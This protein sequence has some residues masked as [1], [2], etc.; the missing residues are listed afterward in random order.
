MADSEMFEKKRADYLKFN[1]NY[2]AGTFLDNNI[3]KSNYTKIALV[4]TIDTIQNWSDLYQKFNLGENYSNKQFWQDESK[5][6]VDVTQ[7]KEWLEQLFKQEFNITAVGAEFL[8]GVGN[9][10][11]ENSVQLTEAVDAENNCY[12]ILQSGFTALEAKSN[13]LKKSAKYAYDKDVFTVDQENYVTYDERNLDSLIVTM[14][15]EYFD[16]EI[17]AGELKQNLPA[18]RV[19]GTFNDY[20]KPAEDGNRLCTIIKTSHKNELE[21]LSDTELLKMLE[22]GKPLS[23]GVTRSRSWK[24]NEQQRLEWLQAGKKMAQFEN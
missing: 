12:Y 7:A 17:A 14:V 21:Q 9:R 6:L 18:F 24:A 4:P 1:G 23:Q 8:E 2:A 22:N 13:A 5:Y 16:R 15:K 11:S 3:Q 19:C 20:G 10:S